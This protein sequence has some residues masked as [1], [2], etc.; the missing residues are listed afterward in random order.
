MGTEPVDSITTADVLAVLK[1]IWTSKREIAARIRQRMETV[2][3]WAI[4]H[5]YRQDNPAGKAVAADY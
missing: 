3:D 2:F 5:G 1:P 4:G